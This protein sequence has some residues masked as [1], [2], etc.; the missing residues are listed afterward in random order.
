MKCVTNHTTQELATKD[1][2][3][4]TEVGPAGPLVAAA[5]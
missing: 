4:F 3:L 5:S 1:S 2:S